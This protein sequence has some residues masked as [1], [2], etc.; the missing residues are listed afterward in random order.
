[1]IVM[2][3]KSY[4]KTAIETLKAEGLRITKPRQL[5]IDLLDKSKQA[6]SAYEIKDLLD[7]TGE[8]VDTV[9]VYR[10]LECL[11]THHLIHR[12]LSSG[13]VRKCQLENE[14]HCH[15][16]QEDHCHHLLLCSKCGKIEEVHCPGFDEL[17]NKLEKQ[18]KFKIVTHNLEFTGLCV[19]CQ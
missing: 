12:I 10:I 2:P 17:V 6:L 5:V 16:E 13:K 18:S 3:S 8:H 7:A 11:E 9:S 1:M 4:S 14:D 19:K 15:L